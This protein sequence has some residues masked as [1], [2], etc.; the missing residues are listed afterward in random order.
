MLAGRQI[1]MILIQKDIWQNELASY[2]NVDKAY[3]SMLLREK[4]AINEKMY[5]QIIEYINFPQEKREELKKE[6]QIKEEIK[7]TKTKK[8]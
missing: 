4:Q 1:K 8:K 6:F 5:K 3:I 7:K 2:C